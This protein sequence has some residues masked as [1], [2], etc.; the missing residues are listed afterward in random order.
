MITVAVRQAGS[1]R[2]AGCFDLPKGGDVDAAVPRALMALH[3]TPND[4]VSY[5]LAVPPNRPPNGIGEQEH[6]LDLPLDNP[7]FAFIVNEYVSDSHSRYLR[8]AAKTVL[9][10]ST[11]CSVALSTKNADLVEPIMTSIRTFVSHPAN[12]PVLCLHP[13]LCRTLVRMLVNT[14]SLQSSSECSQRVATNAA[15]ALHIMLQQIPEPTVS[16]LFEQFQGA[17]EGRNEEPGAKKGSK[18][19][20][21]ASKGE[22]ESGSPLLFVSWLNI[23]L[24]KILTMR[25]A[26]LNALSPTT[27]DNSPAAEVTLR[28]LETFIA[29]YEVDV[30]RIFA[31]VL[32]TIP[33]ILTLPGRRGQGILPALIDSVNTAISDF[34]VGLAAARNNTLAVKITVKAFSDFLIKV[35]KLNRNVVSEDM[36]VKILHLFHVPL[37]EE[38]VNDLLILVSVLGYLADP[39]VIQ[40]LFRILRCFVPERVRAGFFLD[41]ATQAD[42][43][44][45]TLGSQAA[46]EGEKPLTPITP[47]ETWTL[48][49]AD[50]EQELVSDADHLKKNKTSNEKKKKKNKQKSPGV[51]GMGEGPFLPPQERLR[52]AQNILRTASFLLWR[53]FTDLCDRQKRRPVS[54][55][56]N[57]TSGSGNTESLQGGKQRQ[58]PQSDTS[59]DYQRVLR[60]EYCSGP[61]A[62]SDMKTLVLMSRMTTAAVRACALGAL[63]VASA[64]EDLG[65]SV[66]AFETTRIE[67]LASLAPA[68]DKKAEFSSFE[69]YYLRCVKKDTL[70][71]S[72]MACNVLTSLV[73]RP[74]H[75]AHLNASA[76]VQVHNPDAAMRRRCIA[77]NASAARIIHERME[78]EERTAHGNG[79]WGSGTGE[80]NEHGTSSGHNLMAR[81]PYTL[82]YRDALVRG[83]SFILSELSL[84]PLEYL[85]NRY[86]MYQFAMK[87]IMSADFE[88]ARNGGDALASLTQNESSFGVADVDQD[89]SVRSRPSSEIKEVHMQSAMKIITRA[90]S[91]LTELERASKVITGVSLDKSVKQRLLLLQTLLHALHSLLYFSFSQNKKNSDCGMAL[92]VGERTKGCSVLMRVIDMPERHSSTAVRWL[93]MSCVDILSRGPTILRCLINVG[94]IARLHATLNQ[95]SGTSDEATQVLAV[96]IL[97][98]I[99]RGKSREK[100]IAH[101]LEESKLASSSSVMRGANNSPAT[102]DGSKKRL[103]DGRTP[104]SSSD[105][106]DW[107][108]V[109]L[110]ADARSSFRKKLVAAA[111]GVVARRCVRAR[112]RRAVAN[113]GGVRL[114]IRTLKENGDSSVAVGEDI[115]RSIQENAALALMNISSDDEHASLVAKRGL[116]TILRKA[117]SL[118]ASEPG[119]QTSRVHEIASRVLSNLS[120]C[121]SN[122]NALYRAELK[123][124][125][126][127]SKQQSPRPPLG[128]PSTTS[129]SSPRSRR[130]RQSKK[131]SRSTSTATDAE[132]GEPITHQAQPQRQKQKQKEKDG[133]KS[134]FLDWYND[135]GADTDTSVETTSKT[136]F[137]EQ[138]GPSACPQLHQNMRKPFM[139]AFSPRTKR[140]LPDSRFYPPPPKSAG[141]NF[142]ASVGFGMSFSSLFADGSGRLEDTSA[143]S[144]SNR[145]SRSAAAGPYNLSG[146]SEIF[147]DAALCSD[148]E[149]Y[150]ENPVRSATAWSMADEANET[151]AILPPLSD[152]DLAAN[153]P[154]TFGVYPSPFAPAVEHIDCTENLAYE[155]DEMSAMMDMA[156]KMMDS[157]E[158]AQSPQD[159]ELL[160]I[161]SAPDTPAQAEAHNRDGGNAK[162][163]WD[164]D[165]NTNH[166]NGRG[167]KEFKIALSPATPRNTLRFGGGSGHLRGDDPNFRSTRLWSFPHVPGARVS[168][169]AFTPF[170]LPGKN[171][172]IFLYRKQRVH[173]SSMPWP[174]PGETEPVQARHAAEPVLIEGIFNPVVRGP[175][176]SS[177]QDQDTTTAIE[178]GLETAENLGGKEPDEPLSLLLFSSKSEAPSSQPE[179]GVGF[180]FS[181]RR[182]LDLVGGGEVSNNKLRKL[183][184]LDYSFEVTWAALLS[185]KTM[186]HALEHPGGEY[187]THMNTCWTRRLLRNCHLALF[188]MYNEYR[189]EHDTTCLKYLE[190]YG[191][192]GESA[193]ASI[194]KL[195]ETFGMKAD[196]DC[197]RKVSF[198]R[199]LEWIALF[200]INR[201]CD[202]CRRDACAALNTLLQQHVLPGL[203]S[204]ELIPS[205]PMDKTH[206]SSY[207]SEIYHAHTCSESRIMQDDMLGVLYSKEMATVMRQFAP[208]IQPFFKSRSSSCSD[209]RLSE[210]IEAEKKTAALAAAAAEAAAAEAAE[211]AA[212]AAAEAKS[213]KKSEKKSTS[214]IL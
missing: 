187:L 128:R 81:A 213:K 22:P 3:I 179:E 10:L 211:A 30:A 181:E 7:A 83:L 66:V 133:V 85:T 54:N 19:K 21:K 28:A 201:F 123:I 164:A 178:G 177:L 58:R 86:S 6:S 146:S 112:S 118:S 52:I 2:A 167:P 136:P 37:K 35:P 129:S 16:A 32:A 99:S 79:G 88:V 46:R 120:K 145:Y 147:E 90:E 205:P 106:I 126:A 203:M 77:S 207:C 192:L 117:G 39:R 29:Q 137:E 73:S 173:F 12:N 142:G 132:E 152:L 11:E 193:D 53:A 210:V 67:T 148:R 130:R 98:L 191:V 154:E 108:L 45:V 115:Q 18:E 5:Y 176:R 97:G 195:T 105:P 40:E 43:D 110:I 68:T 1:A 189:C 169:G 101:Q 183:G 4:A 141:Q 104:D 144:I 24:N 127:R 134:A 157:N 185:R 194:L 200:G 38:V 27:T 138:E 9:R 198:V 197:V 116:A 174:D 204:A 121:K 94:L 159:T 50:F 158:L 170:N 96:H 153:N 56:I 60:D 190:K 25:H 168:E 171:G 49:V 186:Q 80:S 62:D 109:E 180:F 61:T 135:L 34:V 140:P 206:L 93:A 125:T 209:P 8:I 65:N 36:V 17:K 149:E 111:L 151:S 95:T 64:E 31:I 184:L 107:F 48:L 33:K 214:R 156:Q 92:V 124:R 143:S 84:V 63:A 76:D 13:D 113:C 139:S 119:M 26:H 188:A 103:E 175:A 182:R 89:Q 74:H 208:I 78:D 57:H 55:Y 75:H 166:D 102:G 163:N 122:R 72:L 15:K 100:T 71:C 59:G 199:F 155:E 114:F 131:D 42:G 20:K 69:D 41:G 161:Q 14:Q 212:A 91:T 160:T 23:S 47:I 51:A 150:R 196:N 172:Q 162:G 202:E 70:I 165:V 44:A 87:M 82:K